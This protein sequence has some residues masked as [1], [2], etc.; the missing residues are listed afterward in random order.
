MSPILKINF[1]DVGKALVTAIF[2]AIIIALYGIVTAPGFDV[3]TVDWTLVI[4]TA[5]NASTAAF[6]G[7]IV[8]NFLSN[9][10]GKFLGR[11]G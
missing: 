6:L 7:Y 5:I 8:K 3:F 10:E 1:K 2:T 9:S 4:H 11:V